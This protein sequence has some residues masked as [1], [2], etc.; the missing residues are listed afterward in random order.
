MR[1]D[2]ATVAELDQFDALLD[3]RSPAEFAEDHVPGAIN[4]PVLDDA[5][6]A[7]VGTLYKQVS[8]FLARKVGAALVA[9]NIARHIDAAFVDQDRG[10]RPLVYCWRGGKR[11]GAMTIVL[12][13]IGW[14]ARQL[15]GGYK[16]FRRHVI[17]ELEALPPRL[18]LRVICGMTGTGK[19]RLIRALAA[20][21]AQVI[22][23]EALA[24]HRGSVLGG[25]P[26]APQPSQKA[27][28]TRLWQALAR[29]DPHRPVYVESES[30]KIGDVRVPEPLIAAM[31]AAPCIVIQAETPLRVELL[32]DEY[33]HFLTDRITL[34]DRLSA[35]T[36]LHGHARIARWMALADENRHAE[37]VAELLELHYDP[38]YRRSIGSHYAALASAPTLAVSARDGAAAFD[39]LAAQLTDEEPVAA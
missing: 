6:R 25:L 2:I 10:W 18:D 31:W 35:L 16:A 3:V 38:A 9:R 34:A 28:E 27:F 26:E 19:S 23:L 22:D 29:L 24:A 1:T 36:T 13:E 37:L 5:E 21:G 33:A 17:D 14:D 12:R 4:V 7:R 39:R 8:P 20:R 30:R 15:E 11:S 32:M